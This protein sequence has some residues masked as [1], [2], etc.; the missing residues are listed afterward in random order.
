MLLEKLS[1]HS[2]NVFSN[3]FLTVHNVND[4]E[5]GFSYLYFEILKGTPTQRE[6]QQ[7]YDFIVN[8][9]TDYDKKCITVALVFNLSKLIYLSPNMLKQWSSF[10]IQN[11][12]IT[13]RIIIASSIILE[14]SIIKHFLNVFFSIYNPVKPMK[15]VKSRE[16]AI[17]FIKT[18]V[19]LHLLTYPQLSY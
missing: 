5:N 12:D 19:Q 6:W 9:Y 2:H 4:I 15:F 16:E 17:L 8:L 14:N 3:Y 7:I 1:S 13:N 18:V 10:F 11:I